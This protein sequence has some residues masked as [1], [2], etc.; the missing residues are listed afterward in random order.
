MNL[1]VQSES[2]FSNR[3]AGHPAMEQAVFMWLVKVIEGRTVTVTDAILLRSAEEFW[4]RLGCRSPSN[5]CGAG[6]QLEEAMGCQTAD[7]SR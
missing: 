2:Y 6:W 7:A 3:E 1:E 5:T 4:G